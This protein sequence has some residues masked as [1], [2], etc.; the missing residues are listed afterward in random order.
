M[1][2]LLNLIKID[3]HYQFTMKKNCSR[4]LNHLL[5]NRFIISIYFTIFFLKLKKSYVWKIY[6]KC[7]VGGEGNDP[8]SGGVE[9]FNFYLGN[10]K[11]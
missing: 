11:S 7:Q 4:S 2:Q 1:V 3:F 9:E 5:S 8:L 10:S 6:L